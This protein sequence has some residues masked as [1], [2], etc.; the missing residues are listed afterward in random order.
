MPLSS[1]F[2]L[3][4]EHWS[5]QLQPAGWPRYRGMQIFRALQQRR[6]PNWDAVAE[7]P[8]DLRRQLA[9][10]APLEWPKIASRF[11]SADGTVRYLLRLADGAEVEAVYLPDE[12]FIVAGPGEELH[13]RR[14]RTTFCL[15]TQVGCAVNCQFCFT[16][17]LGLKRS[18]TAGEIVAQVLTLLQEHQL[19]PGAGLDRVNLV[20]MGMGEPFLNYDNVVR[21]IDILTRPEGAAIASRRITVSTSGIVGKIRQWGQQPFPRGRP[22]LAVSLNA[23][24][25][26]QRQRLMPLHQGQGG[27]AGLRDAIAALP[28]GDRDYVTL[29]YVLLAGV[30]DTLEDA[31]RVLELTRGLRCKVNL[32]AWNGGPELPFASPATATVLAFQRHL[33]AGGLACYIRRPRGRDISAAC[34]QLKRTQGANA[35]GGT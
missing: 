16:A 27:M 18:L 34:G 29:E 31:G 19:N 26:E 10:E 35:E 5:A 15:S 30:N 9:T 14:R 11:E 1:A 23:S 20:Y 8:P 4:P 3:D 6:I 24:N 12:E 33:L 22:R 17:T 13:R 7:L 2:A 21:S 28:L 32:I 25:D